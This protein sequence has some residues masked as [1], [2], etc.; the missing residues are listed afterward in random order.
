MFIDPISSSDTIRIA[1]INILNSAEDPGYRYRFLAHE[2]SVIEPD[3]LALQEVLDPAAVEDQLKEVGFTDFRW[4]QASIQTGKADYSGI[5]SKMPPVGSQRISYDSIA[6][7]LKT[8]LLCAF[9]IEGGLLYVVTSHFAWSMTN[10]HLR[11]RQASLLSGLADTLMSGTEYGESSGGSVVILAG[12]LNADESSRTVRYLRG[13]D[14]GVSD[15]DTAY[16]IDAYEAAV[17]HERDDIWATSDQGNSYW[18]RRT[19][20]R[21]GIIAPQMLPQRRIDYIFS[22]GWSYGKRGSPV[23]YHRFGAPR[24]EHGFDH[25]LSDHYGICADILL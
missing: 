8:G 12:D 6:D 23:S 4:A 14:L 17:S 1:Q 20:A 15:D 5:A 25:D 2:L 13:L 16:W 18:G 22:H 19:A 24:P 9:E 3:I 7:N 11:L 21:H 10:E